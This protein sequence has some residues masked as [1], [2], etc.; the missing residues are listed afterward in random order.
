AAF[1]AHPAEKLIELCPPTSGME[2]VLPALEDEYSLALVGNEPA[3]VKKIL[4]HHKMTPHFK[5]ILFHDELG[6][7][8][9]DLRFFLKAIEKIGCSIEESV[10]V[11]DT[12]CEDVAP[13]K[14]LGLPTVRHHVGFAAWQEARGPFELP[15]KVVDSMEELPGVLDEIKEEM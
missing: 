5:T 10:F 11:G 15:D 9:P 6:H 4:E 13:A 12:I 3:V 1:D 8:K 14:L 7:R 2:G